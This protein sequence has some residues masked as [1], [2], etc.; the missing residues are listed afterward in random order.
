MASNRAAE[1]CAP[2][3]APADTPTAIR[4]NSRSPEFTLKRSVAKAQNCVT[5]MTLK[6]LPHTKKAKPIRQPAR[7]A[8]QKSSRWLTKKALTSR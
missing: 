1:S 7:L 6:R 2:A 8:R 3:T 5:A 4:P